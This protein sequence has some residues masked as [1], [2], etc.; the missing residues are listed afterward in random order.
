M[1]HL[2][3]LALLAATVSPSFAGNARTD[4]TAATMRGYTY[5]QQA[6][7]DQQY[8][9][10]QTEQRDMARYWNYETHADQSRYGD[11]TRRYSYNR[12]HWLSNPPR[13][14]VRSYPSYPSY[15]VRRFR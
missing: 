12:A 2:F 7:N 1:R 13:V 10:F 11:L 9:R 14:Y 15:P 6:G 8:R 3:A 5:R 4:R